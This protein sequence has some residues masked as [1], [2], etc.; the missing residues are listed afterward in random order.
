MQIVGSLSHNENKG[1]EQ[2][3][4]K[5]IRW[6]ISGAVTIIMFIL[7]TAFHRLETIPTSIIDE[8]TQVLTLT[9]ESQGTGVIMLFAMVALI[10]IGGIFGARERGGIISIVASIALGITRVFAALSMISYEANIVMFEG[11]FLQ[12]MQLGLVIFAIITT[13]TFTKKS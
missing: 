5:I 6:I 9:K 3:M 8:T 13:F 12:F 10:L 1:E 2:V 7:A 11:K 4:G